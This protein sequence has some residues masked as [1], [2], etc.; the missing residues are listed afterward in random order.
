[1][2]TIIGV[3][4]DTHGLIREQALAALTGVDLIIHAGDVGKPAVL[5]TLS[6]LAPVHAVRG[7]ADVGDWARK[8]PPARSVEVEGVR[9][10]VLHDLAQL[11]IDPAAR[12]YNIVISGHSH[13]LRT[14]RRER[15]LYLNPGSAGPRR[16]RLPVTLARL[17]IDAGSFEVEPVT[18][19]LGEN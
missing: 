17:S 10:Y 4:S 14:E 5:E 7:N 18:L 3:I 8:L 16:F 15:V 1:M 19:V 12:G 9:I 13:K 6:R 11:K 2:P